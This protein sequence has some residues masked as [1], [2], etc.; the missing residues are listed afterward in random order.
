MNFSYIVENNPAYS[1]DKV[2]DPYHRGVLDGYDA[3][4]DDLETFLANVYDADVVED[5]P[6]SEKVMARLAA[7]VVDNACEWLHATWCEHVVSFVED[8]PDEGE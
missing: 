8:E 6:Y 3:A 7:E 1:P 2:R 4:I 5:S